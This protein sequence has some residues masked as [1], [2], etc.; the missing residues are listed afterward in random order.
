MVMKESTVRLTR[1]NTPGLFGAFQQ[2]S[3]LAILKVKK[4]L[5]PLG[6]LGYREMY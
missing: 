2:V 5:K 4:A 1:Q 3:P 6:E